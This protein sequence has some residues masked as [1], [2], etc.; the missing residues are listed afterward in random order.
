MVMSNRDLL[1]K[2]ISNELLE[3][4]ARVNKY[5]EGEML[6]DIAKQIIE[7]EPSRTLPEWWNELKSYVK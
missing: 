3:I 6:D 1:V 5:L 2:R 4:E 7:L